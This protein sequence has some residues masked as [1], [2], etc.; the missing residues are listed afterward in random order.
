MRRLLPAHLVFAVLAAFIGAAGTASAASSRPALHFAPPCPSSEVHLLVQQGRLFS[1]LG[2]ARAEQLGKPHKRGARPEGAR[3]VC[4][5][6]EERARLVAHVLAELGACTELR[7][8]TDE[9]RYCRSEPLPAA[10]ALARAAELRRSGRYSDARRLSAR[11]LHAA[12]AAGR[13]VRAVP[14]LPPTVGG[15]AVEITPL[16]HG[17]FDQWQ[18]WQAE[19]A[20]YFLAGSTCIGGSCLLPSGY[21]VRMPGA[22]LISGF[23]PRRFDYP[24]RMHP[25]RRL[26]VEPETIVDHAAQRQVRL[27]MPAS[28][29]PDRFTGSRLADLAV[30]RDGSV[31]WALGWQGRLFASD[32][33][34]GGLLADFD[35]TRTCPRVREPLRI[36][37]AASADVA[38]AQVGTAAGCA[39]L[40]RTNHP[41]VSAL[42]FAPGDLLALS[43]NGRV[44][45]VEHEGRVTTYDLQAQRWLESSA[46]ASFSLLDVMNLALSYD[47]SVIAAVVLG[48]EVELPSGGLEIWASE[49]HLLQPNGKPLPGHALRGVGYG[50]MLIAGDFGARVYSLHNALFD[51]RGKLRAV[52]VKRNAS[53]L[54]AFADGT[55]EAFGPE[56]KQLY[57]CAIDGERFPADDCEDAFERPGQLRDLVGTPS[58]VSARLGRHGHRRGNPRGASA[59]D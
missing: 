14:T 57:R 39:S 38:I 6:R 16:E 55:I 54:A 34:S 33:R 21:W 26:T 42:A 17:L 12:R 27:G 52:L 18:R 47:G 49:L 13:H 29:V 56:A 30:S 22:E 32:A 40:I 3:G 19:P 31:V 35:L 41:S 1:A 36:V 43:G 15:A 45:A 20:V 9:P 46:R 10:A 4:R 51:Y 37:S 48:K 23:A 11:V 5:D 24:W 44:V 50:R 59:P 8:L 58:V 28:V 2:R 53:V 7:N 25:G